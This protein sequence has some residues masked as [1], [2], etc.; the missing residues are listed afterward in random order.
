[1][2]SQ[3][4]S[5]FEADTAITNEGP[6]TWTGH[7][8]SNWNINANPNGGYALSLLLA[9]VKAEIADHPDPV[10]VNSH[11]LRPCLGGEPAQMTVDVVRRGRRTSTVRGELRQEGKLRIVSLVTLAN[12]D[13]SADSEES[14]YPLVEIPPPKIASPEQCHNRDGAS[15]GVS[16]PLMSRV[17]VRLDPESATPGESGD[18]VM[19]GWIR[20]ADGAAT[21]VGCLPLFADCFPPSMFSLLG[22]IGWVPTVELTVHVRA[23]PAPG[24]IQARFETS[25]HGHGLLIEDGVLWDETGSVVA[26]SR[27]LA[28]VLNDA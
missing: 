4:K 25:D 24:W 10:A 27:Q 23:R 2:S 18:A 1:M 15:Q 19:Q 6:N 11:F 21:S 9:A 22:Q 20:L 12:F 16:L 28:M 17:D 7:L 13:R 26:Q 14:A 8:S 5:Q 3:S